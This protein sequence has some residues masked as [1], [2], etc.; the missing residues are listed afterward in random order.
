MIYMV[1]DLIPGFCQKQRLIRK[2]CDRWFVKWGSGNLNFMLY[3]DALR[4]L[5][6][7]GLQDTGKVKDILLYLYFD[8][9]LLGGNRIAAAYP[10]YCV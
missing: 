10:N 4:I 3:T 6:R 2:M 9:S 5:S 7:T 8:K 1:V